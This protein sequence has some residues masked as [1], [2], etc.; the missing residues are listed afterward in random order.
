MS[1]HSPP[2]P[3]HTFLLRRSRIN[4]ACVNCRRRKIKCV[5]AEEPPRRPCERCAK[6]GLSC[7]YLS[8]ADDRAQKPTSAPAGRTED[9][10]LDAPPSLHMSRPQKEPDAEPYPPFYRVNSVNP[11][12]RQSQSFEAGVFKPSQPCQPRSHPGLPNIAPTAG[13]F[14]APYFHAQP[15]HNVLPRLPERR[16]SIPGEYDDYPQYLLDLGVEQSLYIGQCICPPGPCT[17][18]GMRLFPSRHEDAVNRP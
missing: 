7:E 6:R 16:A 1:H 5:T 2:S 3:T 10:R 11:T 18:G 8:V 9:L 12:Y 13:P 4:V 15:P 17:C 14:S